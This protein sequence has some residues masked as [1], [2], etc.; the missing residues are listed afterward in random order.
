MTP[1]S[2]G[3]SYLLP[4]RY[5][6]TSVSFSWMTTRSSPKGQVLARIDPRDRQAELD[7]AEASSPVSG[8][9]GGR[10]DG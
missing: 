5:P 10:S 8:G 4:R 7:H 9:T 1:K 3:V 2:M 6:A